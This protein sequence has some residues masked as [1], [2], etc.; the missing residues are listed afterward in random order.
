M[1]E[2]RRL[3]ENPQRFQ[4]GDTVY[5]RNRSQKES[6]MVVEYFPPKGDL[7]PYYKLLGEAEQYYFVSQLEL[8]SKPLHLI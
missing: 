6:F 1:T 8:L 4:P 2:A 7:F 5:V 3:K